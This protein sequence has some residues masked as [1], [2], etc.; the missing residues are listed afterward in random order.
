MCWILFCE[1]WVK[2]K[3]KGIKGENYSLA[4]KIKIIFFGSLIYVES[5][6]MSMSILLPLNLKLQINN[7]SL[8]EFIYLKDLHGCH[9]KHNS[10]WLT[11][12]NHKP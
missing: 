1:N 10:R 11:I 8:K 5:L 2:E 12:I 9:L 4:T 3:K 7:F 6:L